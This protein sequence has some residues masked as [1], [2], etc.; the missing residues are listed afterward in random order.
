[1][2]LFVTEQFRASFKAQPQVGN[3]TIRKFYEWKCSGSN[4]P[5]IFGRDERDTRP[6]F[7]NLI[8]AHMIPTQSEEVIKWMKKA[9]AGATAFDMTSNRFVLYAK[10]EAS[11]SF[12]L[13]DHFIDQDPGAHYRL[14]KYFGEVQDPFTWAMKTPPLCTEYIP[15]IKKTA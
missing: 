2:Q 15:E 1:M 13:I 7:R 9:V 14:T 5:V 3:W 4:A 6:N 12:L 10:H 11:P 8:H